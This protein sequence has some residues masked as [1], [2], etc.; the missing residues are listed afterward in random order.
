MDFCTI[1]VQTVSDVAWDQSLRQLIGD[2][3]RVLAVLT[4]LCTYVA[5]RGDCP[6]NARPDLGGVR[7]HAE[8][9]TCNAPTKI[10][11][12]SCA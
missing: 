11:S 5:A 1:D 7:N 3:D 9:N 6:H 8:P 2:F 12:L 10:G 4:K